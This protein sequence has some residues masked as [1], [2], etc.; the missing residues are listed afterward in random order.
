MK[1]ETCANSLPCAWVVVVDHAQWLAYPVVCSPPLERIGSQAPQGVLPVLRDQNK[2]EA[3]IVRAARCGFASMTGVFLDG[4]LQDRGLPSQATVPLKVVALLRDIL[5]GISDDDLHDIL[6]KRIPAISGSPVAASSVPDG[7]LD[8]SDKKEV[9]D[10]CLQHER[11]SLE[12][13]QLR[14]L[15]TPGSKFL[16]KCSRQAAR[17]VGASGAKPVSRKKVDVQTVRSVEAARRFLPKIKGCSIQRIPDRRTWTAFYPNVQPGSRSRRRG[18][19][20]PESA[21]VRHVL[22]WACKHH[23]EQE[24]AQCPWNFE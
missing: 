20:Q 5:V 7:I 23:S 10:T 1:V 11:Q 14:E 15:P 22:A 19:M 17:K 16:E 18:F 8:P 24:G 4:L 21:V 3:L 13:P 9:A 6:L 2:P 12:A